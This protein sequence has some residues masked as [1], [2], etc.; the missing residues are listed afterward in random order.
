MKVLWL[1]LA[2]VRVEGL[3]GGLAEVLPAFLLEEGAWKQVSAPPRRREV[4]PGP[5]H[6]DGKLPLGF[7]GVLKTLNHVRVS[8][9]YIITAAGF[10]QTKTE[11]FKIPVRR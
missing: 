3:V 1:A 2:V 6:W 9:T 8:C 5:V 10:R 11:G 4:S 7:W